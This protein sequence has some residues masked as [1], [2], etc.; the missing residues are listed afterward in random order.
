M[1]DFGD[2]ADDRH[3]PDARPAMSGDW[4]VGLLSLAAL[5]AYLIW[6]GGGW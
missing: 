5:V 3:A 4:L 6:G 1:G 2:V